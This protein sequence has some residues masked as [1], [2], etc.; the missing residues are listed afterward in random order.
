MI[1]RGI[2]LFSMIFLASVSFT[3]ETV[4]F[5]PKSFQAKFVSVVKSQLSGKEKRTILKRILK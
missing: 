2:A 3:K 5:L 1:S 4:S